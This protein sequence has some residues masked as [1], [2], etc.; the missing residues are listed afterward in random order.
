M[1]W[2]NAM[3]FVALGMITAMR[4]GLG[5]VV[6]AGALV[7]AAAGAVVGAGALVGV[8]GVPQAATSMT[9]RIPTINKLLCFIFFSRK[10]RFEIH[11]V[12]KGDPITA[13]CRLRCL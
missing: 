2:L 5:A 7:G 8:A 13:C 10:N 3:S 12:H 4:M 9:I 6:G 1:D 11:L